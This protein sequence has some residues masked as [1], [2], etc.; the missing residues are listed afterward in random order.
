M[1]FHFCIFLSV[2]FGA[3]TVGRG[4][5]RVS[6]TAERAGLPWRRGAGIVTN[7]SASYRGREHPR[8]L[9]SGVRMQIGPNWTLQSGPAEMLRSP[10]ARLYYSAKQPSVGKPSVQRDMCSP[11]CQGIS[12]THSLV[13]DSPLPRRGSGRRMRGTGAAGRISHNTAW[14]I[15]K[16]VSRST[17]LIFAR[18]PEYIR[19]RTFHA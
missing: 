8:Q 15:H 18:T 17:S 4:S 16:A 5:V 12:A 3:Y 11:E 13:H 1:P 19:V 14:I 10:F 6:A 7:S 2:E 9:S